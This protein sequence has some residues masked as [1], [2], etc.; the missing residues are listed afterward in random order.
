VDEKVEPT[1]LR[2]H[3][4]ERSIHGRLISDVA[5]DHKRVIERSRKVLDILLEPLA[6]IGEGHFRAVV[7]TR[8]GAGPGDGAFVRDA[9]DHSDFV[10]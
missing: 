9:E 1:V 8:F 5:G 2:L 6:L 7:A 10:L 3:R 4:L